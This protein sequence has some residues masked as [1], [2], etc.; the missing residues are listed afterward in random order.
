MSFVWKQSRDNEWARSSKLIRRTDARN[1][2]SSWK[3]NHNV[4]RPVTP[5]NYEEVSSTC[6]GDVHDN[7]HQ[8]GYV[9]C[10]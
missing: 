6:I 3:L 9:P 1:M 2:N 10:I 4:D 8:A 5:P 7:H